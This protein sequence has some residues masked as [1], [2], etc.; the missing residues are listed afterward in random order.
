MTESRCETMRERLP[1]FVG[2][3]LDGADAAEVREHLDACPECAAEA[4][5]VRL[6]HTARPEAPTDLARRIDAAARS[7]R[8]RV[9][10]PWW[11]VAAAS[12][13]AV[14]LGIGVISD[15]RPAAEVAGE[16]EVPG[17]VVGA[18]ETSLWVA[19]DGLVAGAPALEGLSDEALLVLLQEMGTET[20]GGAA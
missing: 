5:L 9:Y 13:A 7:A 4:A 8:R 16:V 17:I 2:G 6:L 1:D 15:D 11:G 20:T 14:A 10:H 18:G 3:R 12:V 19:D